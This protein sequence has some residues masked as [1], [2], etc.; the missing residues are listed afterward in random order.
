M[1]RRHIHKIEETYGENIPEPTVTIPLPDDCIEIPTHIENLTIQPY[2]ENIDAVGITH[3]IYGYLRTYEFPEVPTTDDAF[4]IETYENI[5]EIPGNY[6]YD[7]CICLG[8]MRYKFIG[9]Q[10]TI[11]SGSVESSIFFIVVQ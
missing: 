1:A 9:I 8:A 10:Q 2:I 3:K 4:L 6:K 5:E 11:N 7:H